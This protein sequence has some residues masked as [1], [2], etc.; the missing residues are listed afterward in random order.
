MPLPLTRW[1]FVLLDSVVIIYGFE[2]NPNYVELVKPVFAALHQ[3]TLGIL[4]TPITMAEIIVHPLRLKKA[5]LVEQYRHFLME[6]PGV[7]FSAIDHEIGL[8]AEELR[9]KYRFALPDSLQLAA[10][11]VHDCDHFIT[12]DRQLH[13]CRDIQVVVLDD[14]L[15]AAPGTPPAP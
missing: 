7:E 13:S 9:A 8:K 11:I 14:F 6:G 5:E 1:N 4:T 12:N 2:G 15:A 10:G 3:G